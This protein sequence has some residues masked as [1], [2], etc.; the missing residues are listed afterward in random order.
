MQTA[1]WIYIMRILIACICGTVIGFEREKRL[2]EAGI[3]THCLVACGAAL[4]MILSKYAFFDAAFNGMKAADPA[5]IAAQVVSG[6][7]FLGAGMIFVH[8]ENIT[9][10]TTAAG[11]WTTAGI[12]MAI[13][14]GM[15]FTGVAITL[16]VILVQKFLH[17]SEHSESFK[18]GVLIIHGVEEIGYQN[19][20]KE[21]MTALGITITKTS[22]EK[23]STN[24]TMNYTF[25]LEIPIAVNEEDVISQ[26]NYNA[27]LK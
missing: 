21:H 17:I 11:I 8:K 16:A 15:Y 2:K 4:M 27:E 3:R 25:H 7:G 19:S 24:N 12:G 5:R 26:I 23:N 1:E 6:I 13:G 10:L 18:K 9:G 20:I 14:A 22:I